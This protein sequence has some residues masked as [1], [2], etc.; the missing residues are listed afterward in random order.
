MFAFDITGRQEYRVSSRSNV[1]AF[2]EVRCFGGGV[3]VVVGVV[4][5]RLV[6]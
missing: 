1:I 6:L 4:D 5:G 2:I 3:V